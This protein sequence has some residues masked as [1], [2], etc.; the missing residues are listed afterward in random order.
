MRPK[1]TGFTLTELLV[2]IVILCVVLF[3]LVPTLGHMRAIASECQTVNNLKQI[4]LAT[5]N[6]NLT[7][8]AAPS[9]FG[10]YGAGQSGSFWYQLL[11]YLEQDRIYVE[12]P[13]KAKSHIIKSFQSY[14]DPTYGTGLFSLTEQS[15]LPFAGNPVPQWAADSSSQWGVCGFGANWMVFGDSPKSLDLS[16]S[17][18]LSNTIVVCERYAIT[19]QPEGDPRSGAS[20]WAYGWQV[21][22]A[23]HQWAREPEQLK[24]PDRVS[25]SLYAAPYWARSGFS[26]RAGTD[27]QCWDPTQPWEFRNHL[28]PQ[29]APAPANSHPFREQ[30]ANQQYIHVLQGD[31]SVVTVDREIEDRLWFAR[32][33]PDDGAP[34]NDG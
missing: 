2:V 11:P 7:F 5:Q 6:A 1:R 25:T 18:G 15:Y 24:N 4:G 31:G 17:D 29:F 28:K 34:I 10:E 9:M 14:R 12:G 32:I 30:S 27:S 16:I 23:V 13:A 26:L 22:R 21:P 19:S 8:G 3:T 33:C 20:L